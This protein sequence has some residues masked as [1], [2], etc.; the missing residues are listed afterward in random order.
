M[1]ASTSW[2]PLGLGLLAWVY[3]QQAK[4]SVFVVRTDLLML[5]MEVIAD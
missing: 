5:F 2:N 4:S 3:T 1:G